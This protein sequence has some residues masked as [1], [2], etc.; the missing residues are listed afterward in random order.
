MYFAPHSRYWHVTRVLTALWV[1]SIFC[2]AVLIG[3][4]AAAVVLAT[5]QLDAAWATHQ[6]A[7]DELA[8]ARAAQEEALALLERAQDALRKA[9][10]MHLQEGR[11]AGQMSRL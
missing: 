8:G 10:G 6:A 11:N 7:K 2:M 4:Q 5:R 1:V 9:Q 3:Y